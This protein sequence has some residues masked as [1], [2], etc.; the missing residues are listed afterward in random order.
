VCSTA[1]ICDGVSTP[2]DRI[3]PRLARS[4]NLKVFLRTAVV[5][6]TRLDSGEVASITVVQ[7]SPRDNYTEYDQRFSDIFGDW[8]AKA[9]LSTTAVVHDLLTGILPMTRPISPSK[10]IPSMARCLWK[11][12]SLET[13]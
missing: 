7:R 12:Q 10:H 9:R 13:S 3:M 5:N 4:S 6:T 1:A 8:C 11:L 2:F